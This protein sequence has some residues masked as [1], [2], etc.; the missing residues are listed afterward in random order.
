MLPH[1]N[2][3]QCHS[4]LHPPPPPPRS[5]SLKPSLHLLY[6]WAPFYQTYLASLSAP[7]QFHSLDSA[8]INSQPQLIPPGNGLDCQS[9]F[10]FIKEIS[11]FWK[12]LE[13]FNILEIFDNKWQWEDGAPVSVLV[14]LEETSPL[15]LDIR[16][17][18]YPWQNLAEEIWYRLSLKDWALEL[19]WQVP[20]VRSFRVFIRWLLDWISY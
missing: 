1:S 20:S 2:K 17:K 19:V 9:D 18:F 10:T 8:Q 5:H 16:I 14:G 15:I 13:I 12:Q 4:N 11:I 3:C 7:E 6:H